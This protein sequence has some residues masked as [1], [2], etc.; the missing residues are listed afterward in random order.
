MVQ[1]GGGEGGTGYCWH[2]AITNTMT[3]KNEIT[4]NNGC[5]F[6]WRKVNTDYAATKIDDRHLLLMMMNIDH[7]K[8]GGWG[9]TAELCK[10]YAKKCGIDEKDLEIY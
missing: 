10:R 7:Y 3:A 2:G 5:K 1:A 8:I 6:D 9:L 4:D